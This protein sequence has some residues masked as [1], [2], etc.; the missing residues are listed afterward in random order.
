VELDRLCCHLGLEVG[1]SSGEIEQGYLDAA[2]NSIFKTIRPLISN[3]A[4][5]YLQT[6]VLIYKE[7]RPYS[8][9][10]DDTWERVRGLKLWDYQ[11]PIE[12]MDE[13]ELEDKILVMYRAEYRDAREKL[14]LDKSLLKQAAKYIPG[15][16]TAGG[17]AAT[18]FVVHTA[19]RA[20]FAALGGG[21]LAGPIGIALGVIMVGA[22]VSGPA[23]RK[24]IPATVEIMLIGKRIESMPKE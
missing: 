14:R 3:D 18:T 22:Q 23:Y 19:T 12:G 20:P 2:D 21:A 6:L 24:I 17:G 16:G 15:V 10:L 9:A 11:S 8:E 13:L 5:A 7:L 4:P 1:A